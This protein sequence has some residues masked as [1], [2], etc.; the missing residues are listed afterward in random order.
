MCG[1]FIVRIGDGRGLF[2][3]DDIFE[4][5]E[6]SEVMLCRPTLDVFELVYDFF[7]DP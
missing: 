6:L 3:Y 5:F 7:E 2:A 1:G 4:L